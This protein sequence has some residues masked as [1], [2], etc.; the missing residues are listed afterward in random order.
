[1]TILPWIIPEKGF[2]LEDPWSNIFGGFHW[3]IECISRA[4]PT[5][6]QAIWL[7]LGQQEIWANSGP[8]NVLN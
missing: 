5:H 3:A 8:R 4:H 6:T 2:E 7:T 1:M